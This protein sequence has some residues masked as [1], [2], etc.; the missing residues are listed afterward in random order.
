VVV[1]EAPVV[2]IHVSIVDLSRDESGARHYVGGMEMT[3]QENKLSAKWE[4][5]RRGG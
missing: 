4:T 5:Q 3:P 2:T 1:R